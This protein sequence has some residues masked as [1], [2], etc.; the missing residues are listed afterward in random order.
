MDV[1]VVRLHGECAVLRGFQGPAL[2][3]AGAQ[4]QLTLLSQDLFS[5]AKQT[6]CEQQR[7]GE[8]E[9]EG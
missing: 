8:T 7:K 9:V 2:T 5:L 6:V 3:A 4:G 1:S